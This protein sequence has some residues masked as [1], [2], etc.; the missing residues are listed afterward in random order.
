MLAFQHLHRKLVQSGIVRA[1]EQIEVVLD[2]LTRLEAE[3][4]CQRDCFRSPC[5]ANICAREHAADI[6]NSSAPMSTARNKTI[7]LRSSFAP[8][9]TIAWKIDR[10]RWRVVRST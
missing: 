8:N 9:L 4:V 1:K 3:D 2:A 10:P 5:F 7:C 6:A